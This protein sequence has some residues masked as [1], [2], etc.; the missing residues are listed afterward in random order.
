MLV[1]HIRGIADNTTLF[2]LHPSST[3][4]APFSD[5]VNAM[6]RILSVIL[7]VAAIKKTLESASSIC[8]CVSLRKCLGP[9]A[10]RRKMGHLPAQ[11]ASHTFV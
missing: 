4:W 9:Q 2:C 7:S 11:T 3:C 10:Q 5:P 8:P 1:M 6:M